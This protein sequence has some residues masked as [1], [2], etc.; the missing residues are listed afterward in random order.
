MIAN[1]M[2]GIG[3]GLGTALCQSIFYLFTRHFVSRTG[4][5]PLLLLL[6]SHLLMGAISVLVLLALSPFHLP[7]LQTMAIP[8]ICGAGFYLAAQF[9]LF[10]LLRHVE[11]SRVSPMLGSKVV[12][13]A[14]ISVVFLH[15][16]LLLPQW[17]AVAIC[18]L[19]AWLLNDAGARLPLRSVALLALTVLGYCLSDM[20]IKELMNVLTT[21]GPT[22]PLIGTS[23]VYLLCALLVLPFAFRRE[24]CDRRVWLLALPCAVA[25]F[26]AMCSLFACFDRI[27]VVFG[28]IAQATRGIVS[29][30]LG[31]IMAHIGHTHIESH[32]S[33]RIFWRRIAG[34]TLMLLAVT[35]YVLS[36]G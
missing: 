10:S 1:T 11:S 34:A 7:S 17:I 28:N 27:G 26:L 16:T 32:V 31:W 4:R 14:L 8:L 5:T 29:V 30:G 9:A 23:L 13:L 2:S 15:H 6:V 12:V 36:H 3:F 25:W 33:R 35:L 19:S 21:C 24:L 22:A 20:S 18:S